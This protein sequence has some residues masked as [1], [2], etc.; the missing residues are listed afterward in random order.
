MACFDVL[1]G[2]S[3]EVTGA[4]RDGGLGASWEAGS[5]RHTGS[6]FVW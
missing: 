5:T 2:R 1:D 4:G 6:L 3:H